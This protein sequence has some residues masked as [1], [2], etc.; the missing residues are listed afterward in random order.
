[1]IDWRYPMK[2]REFGHVKIPFK[3]IH[4]ELTNVCDFNC[5]FCP[6]P[7]MKR[8][9]GYMDTGLARRLISD[10]GRHGMA[11]KVTFH[12]MGEPTLHPDFFKLL[13]YAA[14][15]GVPVGLT[16]NG[17]GLGGPVGQRLLDYPLRQLDISLQTPDE[18]SFALRRS[19]RLSFDQYSEGI[20]EFLAEYRIRHRESVIKFR[21]LNTV[22]PCKSMEKKT[23]P[24]RVMSS[25]KELRRVFADWAERIHNIVDAEGVELDRVLKGVNKLVAYKWNV[26]EVIPNLF[27]ETYILGDWGHAF[28][29]GNVRDAWAG[30]CFGMRDHFA[31]LQNGDV[32][33]CC[34]DFDGRTS[35]GNLHEQ[36][37]EDIFSGEE[38]GRIMRGFKS[39]RPVHPYCKSCLGGKN[40]FSWLARPVQ[41]VFF[42]Y[43]LK[44]YFYRETRL[45]D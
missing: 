17:A 9:R 29:D 5:L 25:T 28:Y 35:L 24:V 6:K 7:L 45:F 12:V 31:V 40:F 26:A 20:L 30:F 42:L 32:T 13:D 41:T 44:P 15:E 23:G 14:G 11:E 16:T 34:V 33:L 27:F 39:L 19:G 8:P 3:R 22:F 2:Q 43:A 10:I 36:S 4:I 38:A 21:F 1:M 37:L 18:E